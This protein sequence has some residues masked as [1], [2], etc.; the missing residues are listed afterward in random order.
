VQNFYT[1]RALYPLYVS[2]AW[3]NL[4]SVRQ[5]CAEYKKVIF[6]SKEGKVNDKDKTVHL[7]P[8]EKKL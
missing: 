1:D 2:T 3:E 6:D 7:L 4:F 8:P 5:L